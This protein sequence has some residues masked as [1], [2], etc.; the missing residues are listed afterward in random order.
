M[1]VSVGDTTGEI[2]LCGTSSELVGSAEMLLS[3]EGFHRARIGGR[4][5]AVHPISFLSQVCSGGGSGG[6]PLDGGE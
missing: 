2:K 6:D 3:G 5:V 4:S 1:Q